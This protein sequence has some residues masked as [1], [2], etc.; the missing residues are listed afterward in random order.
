MTSCNNAR[1]SNDHCYVETQK[2]REPR[3]VD[4]YLQRIEPGVDGSRVEGGDADED[5]SPFMALATSSFCNIFFGEIIKMEFYERKKWANARQ[6]GKNVNAEQQERLC[7]C[8][9]I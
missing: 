5:E 6:E 7:M 4:K 1:I 2:E 3:L 9:A 8:G